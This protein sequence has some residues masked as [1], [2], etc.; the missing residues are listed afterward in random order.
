VDNTGRVD[1]FQTSEDLVKEVLDELLFKRTRCEESVK[2]GTKELGNEVAID[3]QSPNDP[4]TI[5]H[6]SSRGEIKISLSEMIWWLAF[7]QG[8]C[9]LLTF[10]CRKCLSSFNSLYVLLLNTGVEKG[11]I[12]FLMAT[13]VPE[14]WSLA[15]LGVRQ[16][17]CSKF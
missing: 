8:S 16:L 1:V 13:E 14:S 17:S 11:F 9:Q 15:E 10:S 12:I 2:I 3:Q 6:M 5:T 7:P 4:G